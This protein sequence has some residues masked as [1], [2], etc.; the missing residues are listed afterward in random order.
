MIFSSHST[1]S[2]HRSVLIPCPT[3]ACHRSVESGVQICWRVWPCVSKW[4]FQNC[5]KF[6]ISVI[7]NS[8]SSNC[9]W[10]EIRLIPTSLSVNFPKFLMLPHRIKNLKNTQLNI[11]F[12][13]NLLFST[14]TKILDALTFQRK[15]TWP[16]NLRTLEEYLCLYRFI[17]ISRSTPPASKRDLKYPKRYSC[18]KG[19]LNNYNTIE[20]HICLENSGCFL[21]TSFKVARTA[22]IVS[23]EVPRSRS[24]FPDGSFWTKSRMAYFPVKVYKIISFQQV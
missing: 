3:L 23:S 7:I 15:F 8:P 11:C 12:V 19:G 18:W 14:S 21:M 17:V 1:L 5:N 22:A 13:I 9:F 2:L 24:K 20:K 6:Q 4:T 10:D 16:E